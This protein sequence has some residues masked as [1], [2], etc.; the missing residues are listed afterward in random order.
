MLQRKRYP[1]TEWKHFIGEGPAEKN[2]TDD[3]YF[4]IEKIMDKSISKDELYLL[5]HYYF[6]GEKLS[7]IAKALRIS[8]GNCRQKK[9]QALRKIAAVYHQMEFNSLQK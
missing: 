6:H 7:D 8:D 9:L 2:E 5:K 3:R 1:D 4:F